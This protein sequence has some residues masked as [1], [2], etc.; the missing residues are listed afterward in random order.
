METTSHPNTHLDLSLDLEQFAHDLANT[1]KTDAKSLN[2]QDSE[3]V[4]ASDKPSQRESRS[5]EL[6]RLQPPKQS[7]TSTP[8]VNN[9]RACA[10]VADD[11]TYRDGQNIGVATE[12]TNM[13][14]QEQLL[15]KQR[16]NA[17]LQEQLDAL[18]ME[19]KLDQE[20]KALKEKQLAIQKL[21]EAKETARLEHEKRLEQIKE[22]QVTVGGNP[23]LDW[24]KQQME[25]A[26]QKDSAEQDKKK[27]EAQAKLRQ[28]K[29]ITEQ[30]AKL[31]QEAQILAQGIEGIDEE[32]QEVLKQAG[33]GEPISQTSEQDK[34][35][36]QLKAALTT[37]ETPST[38]DTQKE[39]IKYFLTSGN[40]TQGIGGTNTLKPQLLKRL[41]GE[42]ED[43]SMPDWLGRFNKQEQGEWSDI[44]DDP[45]QNKVRSG[46]L[47]RAT[48][49]IQHKEIWPQKNLMEDYADEEVD[50]KQIAYEQYIAGEAR[51]IETSTDPSEILGR[52]RLMRRMAYIRLRGYDWPI[53]RKMYAAIVRSIEARENTWESNFDRFET[54]LYRRTITNSNTNKYS[55]KQE[56]NKKIWFCRDW[57]KEGCTKNTPHKAWFGSGPSAIQRTVSHVCATCYLKDRSQRDHPETSE[58]CPHRDM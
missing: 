4:N 54:I 50:F 15:E 7:P 33:I 56:V 55:T 37:K 41:T 39:I 31:Q 40:K 23:T 32:V 22:Q 5:T 17:E 2:K 47:D 34:L 13:T 45:K 46:M 16:L 44:S 35:L 51:T 19:H 18:Q 58:S 9:T 24:L 42:T 6:L 11:Q 14:L 49:D 52:L 10:S 12:E 53:V 20:N 3:G 8:E 1:G 28:L 25:L 27:E 26:S 29:L 21:Q 36:Q 48:A 57:N 38:V 43:F 30:K